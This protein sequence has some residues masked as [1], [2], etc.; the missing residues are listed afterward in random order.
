M[1][2]PVGMFFFSSRR[3]HTRCA[4]VTGVQTCALPICSDPTALRSSPLYHESLSTMPNATLPVRGLGSVGII[5]DINPYDLPPAALSAGVN[6]RFENG[7]ITRG[8]V[9]RRVYEFEVGF[10][11]AFLLSFPPV[12]SEEHTSELTSLMRHSYAAFSLK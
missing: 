11:P 5:A 6:V 8:P 9:V 7:K 12:R 4:L 10:S 2:S 1:Y 3:R